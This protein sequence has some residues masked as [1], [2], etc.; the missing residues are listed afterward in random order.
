MNKSTESRVL[1]IAEAGVN[2]NGSLEN[3]K[4]LID[5]AAEA[6]ADYVKFQTFKAEAIASKYA[7]KANYQIDSTGEGE[8]QLSMLKRLELDIDS[9]RELIKYSEERNIKFLSTAFDLESAD[10]LLNLGIDVF[11]IPSGE[12]TNLPYL[13]KIASFQKN[14]ILSTGMSSLDE[15]RAAVNVLLDNGVRKEN[16][17]VLHCNTEYPTPFEDVNLN[18]MQ[19]IKNELGIKIGYSDHTEG[20]CVSVCAVALGANVIEKHFTIDKNMEGPD[21][22]A[23]LNPEELKRLVKEIR[24]IEKSLGSFEK[25][26]SPSEKKNIVNVRKSIVASRSI[27]KGEELREE[28]LTAKRPASGISPMDWDIVIGTKATKDYEEDENISL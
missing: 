6:G 24:I 28:N 7:E 16:L 9:H 27:K 18:A 14:T 20:V 5:I 3:A 10:E 4:K 15:V 21:H 19:T 1:I 12:I 23:S 22:R 2:H 13:R 8:S 17:T 26:P 25:T 11:K